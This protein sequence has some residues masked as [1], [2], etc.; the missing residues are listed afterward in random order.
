MNMIWGNGGRFNRER[1]R[2]YSYIYARRFE[3]FWG[4]HSSVTG[5][6]TGV[7]FD[8]VSR[9]EPMMPSNLYGPV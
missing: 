1:E 6:C 3:G 7:Q 4:S 5:I 8:N 9:V 2:D